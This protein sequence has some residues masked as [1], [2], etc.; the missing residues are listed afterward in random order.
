MASHSNRCILLFIRRVRNSGL[1]GDSSSLLHWVTRHRARHIHNAG[2]RLAQSQPGFE[3]KGFGRQA[4]SGKVTWPKTRGM[5]GIALVIFGNNLTPTWGLSDWL[6][7][8]PLISRLWAVSGVQ[9][10]RAEAWRSFAY[11]GAWSVTVQVA[12]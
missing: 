10:R 7:V 2:Q 3:G 8:L 6:D 5:E 1:S 9:V 4:R 11:N 12:A